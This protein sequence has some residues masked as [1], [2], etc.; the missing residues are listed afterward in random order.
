MCRQKA[1]ETLQH[2]RIVVNDSDGA[3]AIAHPY[4]AAEQSL[5]VSK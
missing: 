5:A 1:I 2:A 4:E 3:H